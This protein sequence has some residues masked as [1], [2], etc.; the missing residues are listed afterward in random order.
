MSRILSQAATASM[1]AQSTSKVWL[2]LL[3]VYKTGTDAFAVYFV[4]NQTNITGPAGQVYT[5]YPFMVALPQ[6]R[7]D[8]P[9]EVT[10]TID[11][12]GSTGRA[13]Y[14]T[15]ASMTVPAPINVDLSIVLSDT[16][17]V[18]ETPWS[19][20]TLREVHLDDLTISGALTYE[21]IFDEA[22]PCHTMSP[23]YFPGIYAPLTVTPT[24]LRGGEV[25]P[26]GGPKYIYAREK[27]E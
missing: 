22:F 8:R 2:F 20:F 25:R 12:I 21:A 5:A 26:H 7:E 23:H 11:N 3:K 19:T 15:I 9:P 10:L 17:T 27:K 18:L 4:N 1:M 16:P 6:D 24:P 13:L 14:Q